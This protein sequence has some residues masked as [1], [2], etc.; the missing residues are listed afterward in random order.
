MKAS[1]I[2]PGDYVVIPERGQHV[3]V[4]AIVEVPE[5]SSRMFYYEAAGRGEKFAA[6]IDDEVEL[7]PQGQA[8]DSTGDAE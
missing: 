3:E 5:M 1:D 7:V 6:R 8:D 4:V 2:R